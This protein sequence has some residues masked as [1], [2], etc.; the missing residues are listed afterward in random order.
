MEEY[1]YLLDLIDGAH[2]RTVR[3]LGRIIVAL[4]VC[5]LATIGAFL[6]YLNQYDF[7]SE[8]VVTEYAQDGQGLNIIGEGNGVSMYGATLPAHGQDKD[9]DG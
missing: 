6:W 8:E 2:A 4:I 5:W 1:K 9:A 7:S 3:W